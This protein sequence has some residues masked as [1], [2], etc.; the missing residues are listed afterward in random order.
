MGYNSIVPLPIRDPTKWAS[1]R[2][3]VCGKE[4]E[5]R[6]YRPRQFCSMACTGKGRVKTPR[7]RD[8]KFKV[9]TACPTCGTAFSHYL[10]SPRTY[11]SRS[12][13]RKGVAAIASPERHYTANCEVCGGE[14]SRVLSQPGRFCGQK[15]FGRWQSANIRGDAHPRKGRT[16]SVPNQH[17]E[18]ACQACGST[19]KVKPSRQSKSRF[20]SRS[21]LARWQSENKRGE[22]SPTWRG[23]YEPYYGPSWRSAMRATRKR[24]GVCQRCGRSPEEVGKEL[25]V[26]HLQPFKLFGVKRHAEANRLENL[27]A[28]CNTCH[29]LIEWETNRRSD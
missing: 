8:P 15:C 4:F 10:S 2:C 26:H 17:V 14:F 27:T 11:C 12:C 18:M 3:A 6:T 19:Y 5:Y 20:C 24:D 23:G 25:D 13:A 21:C 7:P 16:F 1:T 28:L 29:L 9:E 22:N